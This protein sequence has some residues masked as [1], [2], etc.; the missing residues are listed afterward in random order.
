[1]YRQ[2][3]SSKRVHG[4]Q[5]RRCSLSE[6]THLSRPLLAE[7]VQF[8]R[9]LSDPTPAFMCSATSLETVTP[10]PRHFQCH[11]LRDAIALSANLI[12]LSRRVGLTSLTIQRLGDLCPS[13]TGFQPSK[14]VSHP[15][16]TD[17]LTKVVVENLTYIGRALKK[18]F[19]KH[20]KQ[21]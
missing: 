21:N 12:S 15:I 8:C 4:A 5:T 1:E 11:R 16:F 14:H 13:K 10:I 20:E 6:T 2:N 7:E 17:L 9:S 19:K 18:S 3:L